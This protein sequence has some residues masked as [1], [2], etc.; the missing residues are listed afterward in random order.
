MTDRNELTAET[1]DA[2]LDL[3]SEDR[4][5]AAR[6]YEKLRSGLERYFQFKGCSDPTGLAN[7]TIDRVAS[8][9]D[10]FDRTRNIRP[11]A[12]FY[13]FASKI[14]LEQRRASMREVELTDD[15]FMIHAEP[16][17]TDS[18]EKRLECLDSCVLS[19]KVTERELFIGYYV[20]E[21][22]DR[23]KA[24][25]QLSEKNACSPSSLYT[26]IFRIKASLRVCIEKC[27]SLEM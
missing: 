10:G 14:L 15:Q 24:R 6:E 3:F 21:P 4:E 17:D 18:R 16:T 9:I 1:F 27:V 23:K 8:K 19:L 5:V 2:L 25:E 13:G 7:K 22:H 20:T 26:K 12:Y 11:T